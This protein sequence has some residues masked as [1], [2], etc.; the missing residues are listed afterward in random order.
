MNTAFLVFDAG[1]GAGRSLVI[2]AHGKVLGQAYR[3]WSY[4][5]APNA[6]GGLDLDAPGFLD[7]LLQTGQQVLQ[8]SRIPRSAIRAIAIT[9]QREGVVFLDKNRQVLYAGP[10]FDGR[11]WK[12]G[13]HLASVHGK[14]IYFNSGTYPPLYGIPARLLWFKENQPQVFA[15][16]EATLTLGDWI[17]FAL[18]GEKLTEPSLAAGTALLDMHTRQWSEELARMADM[19]PDW[20]PPVFD[21]GTHARKL[22]PDIAKRLNL[23]EIP[24]ILAG[25]DTQCA[26]LGMGLTSPGEFGC[27]AGTTSPV[28]LITAE[29][30]FDEH[31][32]TYTTCYLLPESWILESNAVVTGLAL[33]WLKENLGNDA[34]YDELN[35][36]A[37]SVPPGSRGTLAFLGAEILDLPNYKSSWTGGFLFPCPPAQVGLPEFYRA[38]LESNCYAVRGNLEQLVEISG[39]RTNKLHVCGGQVSSS[40]FTSIL[41]NVTHLPL[42]IHSQQATAIGAAI[43]ASVSTG[44]YSG[45]GEAVQHMTPGST[46][47]VPDPSISLEYEPLYQKWRKLYAQVRLLDK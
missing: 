39:A 37:G 30:I 10:N 17:A 40:L 34:S 46:L 23:D 41:A 47:I 5:E 43:S 29:P 12:G 19:P 6:P 1:T 31:M 35:T 38:A 28:Q 42:E 18:T 16:I 44:T 2:D 27:I 24:I 4:T 9:S 20:L 8:E 7:I 33:R 22:L 45:F 13:E 21:S 32:R 25:G 26:M 11:A 3:E 36:R 15:K 14:K